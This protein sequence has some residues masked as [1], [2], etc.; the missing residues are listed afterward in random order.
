M[1][2]GGYID[3]HLVKELSGL[4]YIELI[5]RLPEDATKFAKKLY[6]ERIGMPMYEYRE[7]SEEEIKELLPVLREYSEDLG[8]DH[9]EYIGDKYTVIKPRR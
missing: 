9:V 6:E 8:S 7:L 3:E 5:N 4:D 2:I 1:I